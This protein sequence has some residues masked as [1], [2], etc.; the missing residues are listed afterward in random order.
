MSHHR[1]T[2]EG[3]RRSFLVSVEMPEGATDDEV[4]EYILDNVQAGRGC[5]HPDDPMS[6][7]DRDKVHVRKWYAPGDPEDPK[8]GTRM[9]RMPHRTRRRRRAENG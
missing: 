6:Q 2:N 1:Y 3:R 9:L 7:L 5:L 8:A 4:R